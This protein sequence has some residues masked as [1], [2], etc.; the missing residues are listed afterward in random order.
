[1]EQGAGMLDG[2]SRLDA[3]VIRLCIGFHLLSDAQIRC[4]LW[5]P[6]LTEVDE[7]RLETLPDGEY[8]PCAAR[9]QECLMHEIWMVEI[10]LE[11][12]AV[13]MGPEVRVDDVQHVLPLDCML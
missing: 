1:M 8:N 3:R 4:V 13:G 10:L 11:F 7:G 12:P 9:F 2:V 5:L 6:G